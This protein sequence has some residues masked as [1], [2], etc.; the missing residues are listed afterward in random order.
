M[1]DNS[2][3]AEN[4]RN[5][6][7]NPINGNNRQENLLWY[8]I[9]FNFNKFMTSLPSIKKNN[10]KT[11]ITTRGLPNHSSPELYKLKSSLLSP[12]NKSSL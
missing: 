4:N 9:E 8:F 11:P 5:I 1:M 12:R 6:E 10:K 3:G 7:M 2:Y